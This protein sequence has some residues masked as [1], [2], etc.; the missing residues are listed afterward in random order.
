MFN[1]HAKNVAIRQTSTPADKYKPTSMSAFHLDTAAFYFADFF[2]C[3]WHCWSLCTGGRGSGS[4]QLWWMWLTVWMLRRQPFGIVLM[5]HGWVQGCIN[6]DI[7]KAQ[8]VYL[9]RIRISFSAGI[10]L[11][12]Q[13][14]H[15]DTQTWTHH[16]ICI[17][18][19][20]HSFHF[21][22]SFDSIKLVHSMECHFIRKGSLSYPENW[23]F[24]LYGRI[25][26]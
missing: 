7:E 12:I 5:S 20:Y 10:C 6:A 24:G 25:V 14:Q 23:L 2:D 18:Q 21:K 3:C 26:H 8:L 9:S 22:I 16:C 11:N 13:P 19:I 1:V 15:W 17:Y 4:Y